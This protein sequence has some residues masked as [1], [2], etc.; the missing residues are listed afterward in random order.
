MSLARLCA[1]LIGLARR[2]RCCRR[3]PPRGVPPQATA[4]KACGTLKLTL[5]KSIVRARRVHCADARRFVKAM[6]KRDCGTT[7]D[8]N[9][10]RF[11]FRG[12][13]CVQRRSATLIKNSCTKGR[14]AISE[15]HS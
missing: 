15:L 2:W 8:C 10:S 7:R 14:K 5:G 6:L 13:S 3:P 12:Y 4:A 11:T 9:F 1:C